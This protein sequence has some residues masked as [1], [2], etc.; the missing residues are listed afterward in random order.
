M[1]RVCLDLDHS[2]LKLIHIFFILFEVRV[3]ILR[4]NNRP[5]LRAERKSRER[6]DQHTGAIYG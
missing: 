6:F 5:L 1:H 4:P 2:L 3:W